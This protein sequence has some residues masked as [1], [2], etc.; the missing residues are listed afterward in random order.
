[1]Q[2]RTFHGP[3]A[4]LDLANALMAGFNRGNL[5]AQAFGDQQKAYVQIATPGLPRRAARRRSW[6]S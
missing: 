2:T 5:R 3:I 4:P 1:M 6:C